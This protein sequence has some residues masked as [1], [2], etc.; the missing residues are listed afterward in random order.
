MKFFWKIF[1]TTMFISIACFALGGYILIHSNFNALLDTEVQTAFDYNDIVYYSLENEFKYMYVSSAHFTA[2]E[3]TD[4]V[5]K[6]VTKVAQSININNMNQKIAFG[7]FDVDKN[8]IFSSLPENFDKDILSSLKE[9]QVGWSLKEQEGRIYVQTI[10]PVVFQRDTL[11]IEMLRNVTYIFD[12]QRVQYKMLIKIMA[13][14]LILGG[15]VTFIVSKLLMRRIVSLTKVTR[16]ISAG[17]LSKRASIKGSDEFTALSRDFNRMADNLEEKMNEL[18]ETAEKKE[19]FIGAF[20][21]ELKTPLT[22]VI[23]YSDM[24]RRKKMSENQIHTCAEYIFAQGKRLEILSMRLL[25]L[26]V[27]RNQ[28]THFVPVYMETLFEEIAFIVGQRLTQSGIKLSCNMEHAVI[29]LE[30]ELMKTVFMNLIDN[31]RKSI[32][33]D[34]QININGRWHEGIYIIRIQDT[35]KGMEKQELSKIMEAFYMVDKSRSKEQGGVGL[36]LTIC[37][38]ILKLHGFEM[39]LDSTVD[40][41]TTVTIIIKGGER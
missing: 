28:K 7:V 26:I 27:L 25:D 4:A 3:E 34:G 35:G 20:S 8:I 15:L 32:N 19:L 30:P 13:G 37:D 10:R 2:D 23:G 6:A 31:A 12:N 36:G 39:A 16:D 29:A 24:L 5:E 33:G 9:N 17:K 40:I 41:G 14:M 22:S 1:F 21:H 38:E 18:K 11:Y